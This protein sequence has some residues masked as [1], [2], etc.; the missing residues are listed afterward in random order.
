MAKVERI[1]ENAAGIDLGT[2]MN[3]VSVDGTTVKTFGTFTSDNA[4][5]VQYLKDSGTKSVVIE[6][7]GVIWLPIYDAIEAAGIE[8]FLV[9]AAHAKNVPGQKSDPADCR[10]L[11]QLHTFGL[12]RA[13]FVPKDDIR[14][15]RTFVRMREDHIEMASSHIMHMQKAFELMN[16]KLKNVISQLHGVSGMKIVKAIIEGQRD[17]EKL[18]DLCDVQIKKNKKAKNGLITEIFY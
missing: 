11:Q 17:A 10:W 5:L 14:T 1:R 12:L 8:A 3:F 2:E 13:S 6:S 4:Q 7:T 16:L 18:A 15:L 9:N